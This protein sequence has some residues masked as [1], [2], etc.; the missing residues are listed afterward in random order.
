MDFLEN[1][2]PILVLTLI[3]AIS[4]PFVA[5]ICALIFVL[6]RI[7]YAVGF[8]CMG[9]RGRMA[10]ALLTYLALFTVIV[11]SFLSVALWNTGYKLEDANFRVLPISGRKFIE[12]YGETEGFDFDN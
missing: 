11:C 6:A 1:M 9:P 12:I 10:G 4:Q 3:T 7:A 8:I 5:A 2:G